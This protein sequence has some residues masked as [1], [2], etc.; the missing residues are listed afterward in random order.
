MENTIQGIK[1]KALAI[2]ITQ[3]GVKEDPIGSNGGPQ[4]EQYLKS[5]GLGKGYAWC[6][7]FVYWC[8]AEAAKELSIPNPVV[9]TAGVLDCWN[10]TAVNVKLHQIEIS[11]RPELVLPGDQVFFKHSATTGHTGI[12][13]MVGPLIIQGTERHGFVMHTIEG[14][15]NE[16]GSREGFEVL[17][18]VRRFDD[19]HL[20]GVIRY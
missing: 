3:I 6:Q 8:F 14:N 7:A 20:L 16:D 15:T 11:S 18:K 1:A 5:V 12:V 19:A 10:K 13:E 9:H 4:V 17:R 2:A